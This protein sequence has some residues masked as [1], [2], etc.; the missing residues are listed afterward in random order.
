M[1]R[2]EQSI[3]M[4]TG[5]LDHIQKTCYLSWF[6]GC[7]LQFPISEP[8]NAMLIAYHKNM[9]LISDQ[10]FV[11]NQQSCLPLAFVLANFE[12]AFAAVILLGN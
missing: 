10:H 8:S 3:F 9:E 5:Q 6:R 2:N 4:M 1:Y 7:N 11:Q 12:A